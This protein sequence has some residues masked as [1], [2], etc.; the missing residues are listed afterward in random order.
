MGTVMNTAEIN[1]IQHGVRTRG[2]NHF[3]AKL[4]YS[5]NPNFYPT[6]LFRALDWSQRFR[7]EWTIHMG[8][9]WTPLSIQIGIVVAFQ[10]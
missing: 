1:F 10:T 5:K 7:T 9:N 2:C 8:E 4:I 6:K 3:I